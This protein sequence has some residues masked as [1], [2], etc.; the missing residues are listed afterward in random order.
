MIIIFEAFLKMNG[1]WKKKD[2]FRT[3]KKYHCPVIYTLVTIESQPEK[4]LLE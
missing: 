2:F 4:F 1:I 3:S